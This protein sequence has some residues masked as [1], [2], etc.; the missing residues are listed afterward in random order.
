MSMDK[1]GNI[2]C[3]NLRKTHYLE[4]EFK[5][6]CMLYYTTKIKRKKKIFYYLLTE[7]LPALTVPFFLKTGGSFCNCS[8]VTPGRGC[9][10]VSK[11]T[12]FRFT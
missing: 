7:A 11:V 6:K 9:S 8:S 4:P 12:V 1:Q 5:C 2:I 3:E 10:S